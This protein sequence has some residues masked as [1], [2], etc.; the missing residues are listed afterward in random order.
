M[1]YLWLTSPVFAYLWLYRGLSLWRSI[2]TMVVLDVIIGVI[3]TTFQYDP[4]YGVYAVISTIAAFWVYAD[5]R[6]RQV[7]MGWLF[8]LLAYVFVFIGL[9]LYLLTRNRFGRIKTE[10]IRSDA[11]RLEIHDEKGNESRGPSSTRKKILLIVGAVLS[12]AG[13]SAGYLFLRADGV[14][15]RLD[16]GKM[17]SASESREVRLTAPVGREAIVYE[18][19]RVKIS[20]DVSDFTETLG[21]QTG[22]GRGQSVL[23]PESVKGSESADKITGS[24]SDTKRVVAELLDSG[25]ASV[26]DKKKG[27]YPESIRV[28]RYDRRCWYLLCG[29]GGRRYSLPDD[30]AIFLEI[31]DRTP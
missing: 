28:E 17:S 30:G 11:G 29:N 9:P 19:D 25:K 23:Y 7:S 1:A 5:S 2:L 6:A 24:Q 13:L 16:D 18:M 8:T 21:R 20:F 26:Y 4:L 15:S 31:V 10:A 3:S 14:W 22:I 27:E 12:V